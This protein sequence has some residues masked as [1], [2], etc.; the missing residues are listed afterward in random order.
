MG[1]L[2]RQHQRQQYSPYVNSVHT[3][4]DDTARYLLTIR[5]GHGRL[6]RHMAANGPSFK[7]PVP[8]F[9]WIVGHPEN[10]WCWYLADF[11]DLCGLEIYVPKV[12]LCLNAPT[13]LMHCGL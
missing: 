7:V 12:L 6:T 1:L 4:K 2:L 3:I 11:L 10:N 8:S 9:E 5:A 13:A